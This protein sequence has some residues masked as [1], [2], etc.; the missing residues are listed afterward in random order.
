MY[1]LN[2][3]HVGMYFVKMIYMERPSFDDSV[4][5]KCVWCQMS[6]LN[7]GFLFVF[8]FTLREKVSRVLTRRAECEILLK[9]G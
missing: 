9:A 6:P 4:F 3:T 1:I 7:G 5:K 8:V 2:D